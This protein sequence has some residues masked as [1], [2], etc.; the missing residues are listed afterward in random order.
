LC[1]D[2]VSIVKER[3]FAQ[4]ERDAATDLLWVNREFSVSIV[5]SRCQTYE[6]GR[7]HWKVR[8]DASLSPDISVAVRLDASNEAVQDYYLLPRLDFAAPRLT[9]AEQ[10]AIELDGYRFDTLDYLYGMAERARW[11]VAA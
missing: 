5:M 1:A 8:L 3:A 9:L 6:S 4:L 2:F 11:G 7:A 10:N